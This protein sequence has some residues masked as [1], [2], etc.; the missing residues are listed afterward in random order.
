M[1]NSIKTVI[2]MFLIAALSQ[3][4]F[5]KTANIDNRMNDWQMK[6]AY[7][8]SA[9]ILKREEKGFV[10]IYDGLTNTQ[11]DDILDDK[12]DRI[13]SMMFTRVKL[14][15]EDG[16]IMIDPETGLA[17]VDDDGCDD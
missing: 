11:V 17:M 9:G 1:K 3:N 15:D 2:T 14:T 12:F 8:P 6:M 16:E 5:A 4:A 13:D 7:Q 10:F